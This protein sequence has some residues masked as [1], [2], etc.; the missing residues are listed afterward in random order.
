MQ[1]DR[2]CQSVNPRWMFAAA[3]GLA[4]ALAHP[5]VRAATPPDLT[6]ASWVWSEQ[7]DD[8]C[9]LRRVF[10]LEARPSSAS[11]LITADNGYELYVNGSL[12]GSD[13]GAGSD[14][15]QSVE[16][17]DLAPRL[18]KGRNIIGIRGIDMGGVRGVVA[19]VRVEVKSQP[20]LELVT[21]GSWR[22]T[23]DARPVDYSHPEFVEG[24]EWRDARVVGPIGMAPWG[25]VAWS[26]SAERARAK[27]PQARMQLASPGKG[28]QW[29]ESVAFLGEDC[30][31]YVPLRGDAW[32]VAFRVGDW[33]RAYTEF[34]LPCPSKIGRRL[35][36]LK[37]G[38]GAK[39]KLLFDARSGVIGSPSASYDG[40]S[41]LV[42]MARE[43]EKF[44]HIYRIPIAGGAPQRL[45]D[46]P[47]HDI[48]PSELP[49]GRIVFTSTR[50]GTFE[51][52]HQ[53]PS[54]ALFRMNAD[55]GDIHLITATPIF[56]NEPKV[57]ASG[58]IAFIRTD[59]FFDRGK[60]ETQLH[61]IRPDGT[62]GLTEFGADVGA[63]YGTRLRAFGFGSPAPLPGGEL[64]YI[65]SHGNFIG[66]S[67]S[68][69]REQRRLPD[70][71]GDLAALP[72]GRLL[73]TVLRPEGKRMVSDVL[74]VINPADNQIVSLFQ[75]Q[76]GG[77]HSP[78]FLGARLRPPVIPDYVDRGRAD[79][80]GAT[81]F[82]FCQ[83]ARFTT[84]GKADW[85]RVRAIRV[86]GAVPLTTRSSHSHIVHVGHETVELGTVPLAADGSFSIEVPADMPLALQAVDAEG[87][88]ELN[89][90]SWLYVRPGE[91]RSCIGCHQPRDAAPAFTGRQADAL[92]GPPLKLL[93]QGDPH[94]FRGNNPG[95][96]GMMDLQFERF[97]E[98]A[99]IN[100]N[101]VRDPAEAGRQEEVAALL[102][103]LD[104]S[105]EGLKISAAQRLG[106][107]RDHGAAKGLAAALAGSGREARVA[108][109]LAL[110]SCGTRDS[111]S[112]L[113][114]VLE[115]PAPIVVQAAHL[116]LENLTGHSELSRSAAGWK[117]WIDANPWG[118]IEGSLIRRLQPGAPVSR[119]TVAALGHMGG[120]AAP[121]RAARVRS[122]RGGA[123]TLSNLRQRQ[124]H[125]HLHLLCRVPLESADSSRSH[126]CHRTAGGYEC[127][128]FAAGVDRC[129]RG[130]SNRK[131]FSGGGVD[132]G[133][134]A[135]RHPG[136]GVTAARNLCGPQGLL[137][138]R[139]VV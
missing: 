108:I 60:V 139:G 122:R 130:T 76:A 68:P 133:A 5:A 46:G 84:K 21:D 9:D 89:E 36:T 17:Y 54:R 42:A 97:R 51:E 116:A 132:R 80:G 135:N 121:R 71:L 99:S 128:F 15:W 98:C 91:R 7:T 58:R 111:V 101:T 19:A 134:R 63:D 13:V 115:D 118:S 32:G 27:A 14:V 44:F 30:S 73:C 65:S 74:G 31:V 138:L 86:L 129:Q 3:I 100:R 123:E 85:D 92:R 107:L 131:P 47:F 41:L 37:P 69:Q 53:P 6:R 78:V 45:T 94:R 8:T 112:A 83:D 95:V 137:G 79:H 109:A 88:S 56:D 39:P 126:A 136:G 105:D 113:L 11:I 75:S 55:G 25:R 50:I 57:M 18:A 102:R 103:Q 38:P 20:T 125:R 114:P 10:V 59:N 72:D 16:R 62:D 64:A 110:A 61:S 127:H 34:D 40:R 66:A 120:D 104:G 48:D 119:S 4:L 23:H 70:G 77:I 24:A 28:F 81:G 29:P 90:M 43:S 26:E 49:D 67:G 33:S 87:R 22:V 35:Y 1:Q 2:R 93:G 96:T 106:M 12:V 82:L 52:Y 124:P 117:A